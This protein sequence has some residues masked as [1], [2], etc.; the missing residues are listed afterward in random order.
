[1]QLV[2]K[3]LAVFCSMLRQAHLQP[4]P[5]MLRPSL[6]WAV[7]CGQV[8]S[9]L[10]AMWHLHCNLQDDKLSV[11]SIPTLQWCQ[12]QSKLELMNT[13]YTASFVMHIFESI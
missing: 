6:V 8:R 2:C 11:A 5:H 3:I 4:P 1:M 10:S 12:G 13:V 9:G 7:P